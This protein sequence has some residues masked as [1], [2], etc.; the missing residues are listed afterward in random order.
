MP[1]MLRSSH[2]GFKLAIE[3][4]FTFMIETIH[5]ISQQVVRIKNTVN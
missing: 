2:A 4:K 1:L 3:E 5:I